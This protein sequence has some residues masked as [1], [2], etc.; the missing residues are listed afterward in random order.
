M[1]LDPLCCEVSDASR[2]GSQCSVPHFSS[3]A[4]WS[5]CNVEHSGLRAEDSIYPGLYGCVSHIWSQYV[6][7]LLLMVMCSKSWF[8][9]LYCY[10]RNTSELYLCLKLLFSSIHLCITVRS[11]AAYRF[12]KDEGFSGMQANGG[13]QSTVCFTSHGEM[14]ECITPPPSQ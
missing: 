10:D 8:L 5:L 14:A 11:A 13:H 3:W 4:Y 12:R 7:S 1:T 9:W 6:H 2:A